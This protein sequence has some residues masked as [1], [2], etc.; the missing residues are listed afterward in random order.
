MATTTGSERVHSTASTRRS[1]HATGRAV[2]AGSRTFGVWLRRAAALALLA[3]A[4]AGGLSQSGQLRRATD[5]LI[6]PHWGWLVAAVGLE[7][8]SMV[9]FA[10]I[11]RRLLR[12]GR[13]EV[14][15]GPMVGITLAANALALSL[16][17]GVAWGA[18]WVFRRLRRRG[19]DSALAGW[20][21]LVAG[22]LGSFA[23]FLVVA[24]GVEIAG[25]QG[26]VADARAPMAALALLPLL[27]AVAAVLVR[28]SARAGAILRRAEGM[29]ASASLGRRMNE[30]VRGL[31]TRMRQVRLGRRGWAG[32]G[33]LAGLNWLIDC[34]CL[35]ACVW[36]VG[37]SVP[38]R[39]VLLAYGL[40]Q[41]AA[42]LPVIPGGL[43]VVEGSLAVLLIAY[44]MPANDALASVVLYRIVSFWA[45]VPAGWGAWGLISWREH[46]SDATRPLPA[47]RPARRL[48][49]PAPVGG[50]ALEPAA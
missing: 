44:G 13:I 49:P 22:G 25:D 40:S 4:I 48:E 11:Q 35:V 46:R 24:L 15:L 5:L 3:G 43:G 38:W 37:G 6:H 26:P 10:A 34:A 21:V 12:A 29:A 8:T 19:A 30:V 18:P 33:A 50:R 39:G 31:A 32:A 1:D 23:L 7:A 16:P 2:P 17:G 14:G 41:A 20:V 45:V 9:V 27:V 36:A 47:H 42:C 28:R